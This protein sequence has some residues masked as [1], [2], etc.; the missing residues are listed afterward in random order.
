MF[1][2]PLD[3]ICAAIADARNDDSGMYR[4][5]A[6]LAWPEPETDNDSFELE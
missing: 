6:D 3:E 4:S 5:A 2:V 1:D